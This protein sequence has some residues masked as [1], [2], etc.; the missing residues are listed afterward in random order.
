MTRHGRP[1]ALLIAL[2]FAAVA[3]VVH[4]FHGGLSEQAFFAF[5]ALVALQP[6]LVRWRRQ[7]VYSSVAATTGMTLDP[8]GVLLGTISGVQIT[9]RH[10]RMRTEIEAEGGIPASLV[11]EA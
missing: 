8:E 11:I 7:A 3:L 2:F 4:I 5:T 9:V 6:F 1:R 10:R